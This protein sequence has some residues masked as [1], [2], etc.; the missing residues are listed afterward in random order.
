MSDAADI[1][2]GQLTILRKHLESHKCTTCMQHYYSMLR[3]TNI[4]CEEMGVLA[5]PVSSEVHSL[6]YGSYDCSRC[7]TILPEGAEGKVWDVGG[8]RHTVCPDQQH[9]NERD[10]PPDTPETVAVKVKK[11][12]DIGK[13]ALKIFGGKRKQ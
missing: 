4:L 1:L 9:D 7:H 11:A 6:G 10:P 2:A 8:W 13:L 3:A 12:A 5:P